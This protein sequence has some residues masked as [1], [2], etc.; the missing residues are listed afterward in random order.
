MVVLTISMNKITGLAV[1][2]L[3]VSCNPMP[4]ERPNV[5][6]ILTDDQAY[7]DFSMNGNPWVE[8]PVI[9]RL[10][11]ESAYLTNFYVSPVCAP[12]RASML[13]GRYFQ[14]TGVT[15]VTRGQENMLLNEQ[16][17][18]DIFK[19]NG[20]STGL[21]GKWHNG[22]HYP[23]HPN[24]RGFDEFY[25]FCAGHW[26]NYFDT[27]L[28]RNG[29]RVKSKGYIVDDITT[30]AIEFIEAGANNPDPFF[31]IL[32]INTPH[33]PLQVPDGYFDKYKSKGADDFNA[34]IYGMCENIDDN[35]G[36]VLQ[37]LNRLN[38]REK[39]I[40]IYFSDNGPV[41][42]RYNAGLKGLKGST[43]EGGVKS[44]FII[45]WPGA[46]KP[47][48]WEG[49]AAHIDI[50]PTLVE[51]TGIEAE[52]KNPID[53]K[54]IVPILNGERKEVHENIPERWGNNFRLRT[55]DYLIVNESL[56]DMVLDP[57]QQFEMSKSYPDLYDSLKTIFSQ[58]DET[59][60][61]T[62]VVDYRIPI[63]YKAFP[64]SY[65]PAHEAILHPSYTRNDPRPEEISYHA[66]YG[67]AN[68]WIDYWTD[69]DAYITWEIDV[70]EAGT[71]SLSL[72]Y[73]CRSEDRGVVIQLDV[74]NQ[75]IIKEVSEPFYSEIIELPDRVT[76]DAEAPEKEWGVLDLGELPLVN[77]P[78]TIKLR[79]LKIP[80]EKSIE[81]KGLKIRRMENP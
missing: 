19:N 13:T 45:S 42:H 12:T 17:I 71:F 56:Y 26:T 25:G 62:A 32:S 76:L 16:T 35:V 78:S 38:I 28:E 81:V 5:I 64:E 46:I 15:G 47:G 24:G 61:T 20:Y 58:W 79:S 8:T 34:A 41:N 29:Q 65:L 70:V 74:Q 73:N 51:L 37:T 40:V 4:P 30:K 2:C 55:P 67:W 23:Y 80:G 57:G 66:Y 69:K 39:T 10:A 53:G 77:G 72:E 27:W 48:E 1:L 50:L 36:R 59:I 9:D 6:I 54:S 14:R 22:A 18:A 43:D 68:D 33:S 63:G 75:E 49:I 7:G 52:Y 21:F 3:A 11:R 44:P 31:C 60:S